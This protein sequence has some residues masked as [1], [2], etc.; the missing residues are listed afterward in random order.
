MQPVR[1]DLKEALHVNRALHVKRVL[2]GA[3]YG[4]ADG[5]AVDGACRRLREAIQWAVSWF[6]NINRRMLVSI[7]GRYYQ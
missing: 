3:R 4:F 2:H 5:F 7:G 1:D 6:E